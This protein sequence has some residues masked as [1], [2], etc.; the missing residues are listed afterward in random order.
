MKCLQETRTRNDTSVRPKKWKR[1]MRFGTWNVSSLYRA[2]SLTAASRELAS[3]GKGQVAGTC[4]CGNEP[5]D[6]IKCG[7]CLD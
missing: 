6:S 5:S 3:S 1:D 4:E 7:K 2:G